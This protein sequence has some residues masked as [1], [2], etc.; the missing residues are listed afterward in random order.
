MFNSKAKEEV[1]ED[2][3]LTQLEIDFPEFR[4]ISV[5]MRGELM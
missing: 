4:Q 3:F 2:V 1:L 5:S